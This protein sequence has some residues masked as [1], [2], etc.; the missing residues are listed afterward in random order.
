GAFPPG[1]PL[2][3][4]VESDGTTPMLFEVYC[5]AVGARVT[6]A[7]TGLDIDQ[8]GYRV[9]VDG[10]DQA[11]VPSNG[12]AF[13]H[14]DPGR[15]TIALTGLASNCAITGPASQTVTIA[16]DDSTPVNFAVVCTATSG[17]I[18]I[19]VDASGPGSSS[20]T[21]WVVLDG[22]EPIRTE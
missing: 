4:Y 11:P 13:V 18:A 21:V 2:E 12:V 5:P 6:V 1:T 10:V 3:V 20:N 17:V 22:G 7:T 15:R 9:S 8:D 16:P 14:A 19:A